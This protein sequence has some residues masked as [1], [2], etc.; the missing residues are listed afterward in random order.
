MPTAC[1]ALS[2]IESLLWESFS[3]LILSW[4]DW[5]VDFWLSGTMSRWALSAPPERVSPILSV[6]DLD[7]FG[8]TLSWSSVKVLVYRDMPRLGGEG[9]EDILSLMSLRPE[10]VMLMVLM[11]C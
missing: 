6:V 11:E 9:G 8:V 10:S 4:A 1:L 2:S 3:R 7:S 5:V